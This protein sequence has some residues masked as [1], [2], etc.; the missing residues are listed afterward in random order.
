MRGLLRSQRIGHQQERRGLGCHL[1][2]T[3]WL[4]MAL[5]L[6]FILLCPLWAYAALCHQSLP[7]DDPHGCFRNSF[8]FNMPVLLPALE[9]FLITLPSFGYHTGDG[10]LSSLP[11]LLARVLARAPPIV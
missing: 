1:A 10:Q 3:P 9:F 2:P 6:V 11:P 4:S 8:V 7:G 5:V